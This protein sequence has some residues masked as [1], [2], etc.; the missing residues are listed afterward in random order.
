MKEL[1]E[2][3]SKVMPEGF[4]LKHHYDD[5]LGDWVII[6]TGDCHSL[7]APIPYIHHYH[8]SSIDGDIGLAPLTALLKQEMGRKRELALYWDGK[9]RWDCSTCATGSGI[10]DADSPEKTEFEA[11]ALAYLATREKE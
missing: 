11:V 9:D 7:A 4:E 10:W 1:L 8:L 5:N 2:R 3:L 6:E